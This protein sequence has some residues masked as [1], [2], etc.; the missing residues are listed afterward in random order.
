MYFSYPATTL[1]SRPVILERLQLFFLKSPA[2]GDMICYD[3]AKVCMVYQRR[4]YIYVGEPGV[5]SL[6]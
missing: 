6:S 5:K 2:N 3:V 4:D 1:R